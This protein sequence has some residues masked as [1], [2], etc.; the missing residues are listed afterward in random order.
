VN[1]SYWNIVVRDEVDD[2]PWGSP[3]LCSV[4]RAIEVANRPDLNDA[5]QIWPTAPLELSLVE[6]V[7]AYARAHYDTGGW[8]VI[9]EA[10]DDDRIADSLTVYGPRGGPRQAANLEEAI[11]HSTLGACVDIWADQQAD[12]AIEGCTGDQFCSYHQHE[13]E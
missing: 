12:A 7:K 3:W 10:W 4:E 11:K 6:Q 2:S 1:L 5:V 8:N 9:I 13:G